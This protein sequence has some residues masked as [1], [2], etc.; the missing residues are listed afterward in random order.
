MNLFSIIGDQCT[1]PE[2]KFGRCRSNALPFIAQ[3]LE[4]R[5]YETCSM[6]RHATKYIENYSYYFE[7]VLGAP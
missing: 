2:L 7:R 4:I 6:I 5:I 1:A 3:T